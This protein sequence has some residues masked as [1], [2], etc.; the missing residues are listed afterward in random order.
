[1]QNAALLEEHNFEIWKIFEALEFLVDRKEKSSFNTGRFNIDTWKHSFD[2]VG[3]EK[4]PSEN[5]D[6][7]PIPGF[8]YESEVQAKV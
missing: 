4:I 5:T 2:V 7:P 8:P 6:F 1:M 3:L